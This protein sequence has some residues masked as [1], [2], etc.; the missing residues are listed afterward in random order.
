MVVGRRGIYRVGRNNQLLQEIK[1]KVGI[2]NQV[3]TE[4]KLYQMK[5]RLSNLSIGVLYM[6]ITKRKIKGQSV[7]QNTGEVHEVLQTQTT[8]YYQRAVNGYSGAYMKK[9]SD[10]V[11]L[12]KPAQRLFFAVVHNVNDYNRVEVM[13]NTLSNEN[14]SNISKAKK[15]LVEHEFIAKIGKAWVLN[16]FVVLARYQTQA[17]QVQGEVQQIWRRYV[18]DMNDW[19]DGIDEDAH[20]LYGVKKKR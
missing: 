15:E 8:Y 16:P 5:V 9:M 4:L 13:W 7:N 14:A 6:S 1:V 3:L 2:I 17:P 20:E 19:Y 11:E 10:I 12:G 18:E